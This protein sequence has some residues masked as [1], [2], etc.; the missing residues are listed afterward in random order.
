MLTA[1]H[2]QHTLEEIPE[3]LSKKI[4]NQSSSSCLYPALSEPELPHLL[5]GKNV[6]ALCLGGS[7]W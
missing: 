4:Q 2:N 1:T 3:K 6:C 7:P 5:N